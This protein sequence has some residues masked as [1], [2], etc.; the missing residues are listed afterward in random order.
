MIDRI[1]QDHVFIDF[2]A[3]YIL[4]DEQVDVNYPA[5]FATVGF[6]LM[7]TNLLASLMDRIR[8][9]DGYTPFY[10]VD[11]YTESMCDHDGWYDFFIGLN[12]WNETKVDNCIEAVVCNS[13]SADEGQRYT[14]DLSHEEQIAMFNRLD[15]QCRK[16]LGKSCDELLEEAEAQM[17]KA[18]A[19]DTSCQL[20]FV[21][22]TDSGEQTAR[23]QIGGDPR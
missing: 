11:E 17:K 18:W 7:S 13:H 3:D 20:M 23:E 8:K 1:V 12:A 14:I 9:E 6:Q 5:R 2:S 22:G 19:E 10:P 15:E 16:H 4:G 21:D